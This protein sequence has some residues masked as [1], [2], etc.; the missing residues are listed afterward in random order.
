MHSRQ[1]RR[2]AIARLLRTHT[3]PSQAALGEL[4]AQQ[5]VDV[6]QGTLSRDLHDMGVV[7]GPAGY[8]LPASAGPVGDTA[9]TLA[10]TLHSN[11]VSATVAQN[12]IVLRTPPGGAQPLAVALDAAELPDVLGTIGGDD[13]ILVICPDNKRAKLV[14]RE[15]AELHG[16]V[17]V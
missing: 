11:L 7:K 5:D 17:L 13:T 10:A 3:V 15:L 2:Q 14:A 1:A 12:Q 16:E 8:E 9:S 6:N 4:L